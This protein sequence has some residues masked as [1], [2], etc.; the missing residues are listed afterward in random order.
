LRH[1]PEKFCRRFAAEVGLPALLPGTGHEGGEEDAAAA[2]TVSCALGG[3]GRALM[4][5]EVG[6]EARLRLRLRAPG[7]WRPPH[8]C[9]PPLPANA[10]SPNA[11]SPNAFSPR[12]APCGTSE[13]EKRPLHAGGPMT[14]RPG[15]STHRHSQRAGQPT[16]HPRRR[17]ARPSTRRSVSAG[18]WRW[19]P[20]SRRAAGGRRGRRTL[21]PMHAVA[22]LTPSESR[23]RRSW[24]WR[25][26]RSCHRRPPSMRCA[27]HNPA[28]RSARASGRGASR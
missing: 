16:S 19:R 20:T 5:E 24:P 25:A 6:D 3:D 8:R 7:R 2:P 14:T 26:V 22:Q 13:I 9:S 12:P 11:F 15:A 23:V 1:E 18:P 10:F 28:R 17:R 4:I 27:R 21:R